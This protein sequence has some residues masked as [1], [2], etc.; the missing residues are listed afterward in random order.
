VRHDV[1]IWVLQCVGHKD[2]EVAISVKVDKA[3]VSQASGEVRRNDANCRLTLQGKCAVAIVLVQVVVRPI[4][5][6][7]NVDEAVVVK[8]SKVN[9]APEPTSLTCLEAHGSRASC[10]T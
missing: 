8:V 6:D 1:E 2:V 4:V 10:H 5:C 3:R 9:V 7:E